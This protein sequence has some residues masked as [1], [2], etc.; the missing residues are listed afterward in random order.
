MPAH[1][2][3]GSDNGYGVENTR[4]AT[5]EP[6]EQRPAGQVQMHPAWRALLQNIE[7][8]P[9][10]QDISFEPLGDL[11]QCPA[12]R[13]KERQLPSSTGIMF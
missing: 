1:D 6:N 2:G 12:C 7:L 4:T 11:K 9:E 5:I 8:M 10:D 13:R 3:L